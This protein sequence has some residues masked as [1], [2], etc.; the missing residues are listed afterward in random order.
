[1]SVFHKAALRIKDSK[2]AIPITLATMIGVVIG[3][4]AFY[5]DYQSSLNGYRTLPTRKSGDEVVE[6]IALLPQIGQIIFFFMFGNSITI[7]ESGKRIYNKMYFI[8]GGFLLLFDLGTDMFYKAYGLP[9]YSWVIAFIKSI[10]VFTIGSELLLM[11]S[12]GIFFELAPEA[13]DQLGQLVAKIFGEEEMDV[14]HPNQ[15][16]P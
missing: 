2:F 16:R 5:E 4:F 14:Q 15:R 3:L 8:V 1:M 6:V 7:S 11:A 10:T 12:I 13:F 9:W